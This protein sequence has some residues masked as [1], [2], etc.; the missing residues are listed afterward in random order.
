MNS[1]ARHFENKNELISA[2]RTRKMA[3]WLAVSHAAAQ[4]REKIQK[5]TRMLT[6]E[7]QRGVSRIRRR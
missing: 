5:K 3:A 1:S 6:P 2:A 4:E 7:K